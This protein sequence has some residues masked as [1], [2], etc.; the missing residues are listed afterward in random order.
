M[1][2]VER[3]RSYR[4]PYGWP[5]EYSIIVEPTLN[6]VAADEIERLRKTLEEIGDY[7]RHGWT[8]QT[9]MARVALRRKSD[10]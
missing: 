7:N 8:M 10:G 1:D 3:L 2:I 9:F 4:P 5:E 6:N